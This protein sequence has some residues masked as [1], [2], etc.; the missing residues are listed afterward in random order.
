MRILGKAYP[1]AFILTFFLTCA[2]ADDAQINGNPAANQTAP[3]KN[4]AYGTRVP[5]AIGTSPYSGRSIGE[6]LQPNDLGSKEQGAK[7]K[8][9]CTA[10]SC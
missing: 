6:P 4:T 7:E 3:A 10:T 1:L 5:G 8:N 9:R 2:S